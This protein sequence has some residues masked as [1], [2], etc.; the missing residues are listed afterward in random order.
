[1]E[2][3]RLGQNIKLSSSMERIY[4]IYEL[5]SVFEEITKI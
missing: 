5:I 3:R 2:K 4:P 1:M